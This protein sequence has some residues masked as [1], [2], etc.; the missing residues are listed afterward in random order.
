MERDYKKMW[1]ERYSQKDLVYGKEANK[2]F[3]EKLDKLKPGKLFMPGDGEGRNSIYAAKNN[4][5]VT[6][7][8]Y[9]SVAVEKAKHYAE[10]ENVQADFIN[11]DL[12]NYDYPKNYYDAVGII[13]FH[14][15][16]PEKEIVH[17]N[18][19]DSI[20]TG[21]AVIL[22]VFSNDQLKYDSGGP[23]NKNAL[24]SIEEI[25]E[26]YKKFDHIEL[27]EKEIQLKE[28]MHHSGPASVIRLFGIKK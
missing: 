14:L 12:T 28:S 11:A 18:I 26:Y 1:D 4:W 20:K 25:A 19:A 22:E 16:S 15:Q 6:S 2:Y 17:A 8:D 7:V 27:I 5:K 24:Y 13:F 23:R 21:G 10:H 3:K 9:S